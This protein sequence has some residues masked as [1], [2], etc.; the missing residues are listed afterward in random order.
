MAAFYD[1]ETIENVR[2]A[3]PIEDV[4]GSYV[5]L[6]RKGSNL[7]GLCPFHNEK[8]PSFSVN[9][10]RQIFY[11]FGSHAGGNVFTFLMKYEN[12]TFPES[13]R[14][15]AERAGIT[16]PEREESD[17]DRRRRSVR[18][19]L[20]SINKDA[21]VY[22][23]HALRS[24]EGKDAYSYLRGR[25]LSDETIKSFGLGYSRKFRDDLYK[26]IKDKGYPDE[27]LLKS[28]IISFKEETGIHDLFWN[29]VMFPIQD[30]NGKVIGFG[31]RVMGEGKPKYV[32]SPETDVFQKSRNM[33]ALF[34]ARKTKRDH[35]LLCEGYMD[36]IALHQAGYENALASLGTA[37]TEGHCT[38]MKRFGKKVMICYDSDEAGQNSAQRAVP[39][40]RS[41]GIG[42]Y[43]IDLS[44]YKDQDEFIKALGASEFDKRIDEAENGFLFTVRKTSEKYDLKDPG[45]KT[46]FFS[47]VARMLLT[48]EA[49]VERGSYLSS[50]AERFNVSERDL[51]DLLIRESEELSRKP[52]IRYV[53]INTEKTETSS[54]YYD[55][56]L[57]SKEPSEHIAKGMAETFRMFLQFLCFYPSMLE[58]S[59]PYISEDDLPGIYRDIYKVIAKEILSGHTINPASIISHFP[60]EKGQQEAGRIFSYTG[61]EY[62]SSEARGKAFKEAL[63]RIKKER[64]AKLSGGSGESAENVFSALMDERR[65]L[66]E[67]QRTE[68]FI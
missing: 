51:K 31:G 42:C 41:A 64:L 55:S 29:R 22:F 44:P 25:N 20:L 23:Y 24:D 63:L 50:V 36:V 40:L 12:M 56:P 11:C 4:V 62:D 15:L 18:E 8:T 6:Q 17:D 67:I 65:K 66:S 49:G 37:L 60:D 45:E 1:E 43:V 13:V 52:K 53:P 39:M 68:F 54:E 59:S 58:R 61:E 27:L 7:M 3:N 48:L 34:M 33:Y 19:Q 9:P 21:A 28:G 5:H 35:F 14:V 46:R 26:Y 30:M 38:L 16:L 47:E 57:S 2:E 32:N 10:S